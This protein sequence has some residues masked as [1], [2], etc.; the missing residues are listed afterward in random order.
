MML[1]THHF[2]ALSHLFGVLER[3]AFGFEIEWELCVGHQV[4]SGPNETGLLREY[5]WQVGRS[6]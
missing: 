1:D 3:W 6:W 4:V 5:L 2:I